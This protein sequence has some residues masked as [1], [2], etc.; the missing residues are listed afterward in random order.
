MEGIV[1]GTYRCHLRS[2][3]RDQ[4]RQSD[5]N[6]GGLGSPEIAADCADYADSVCVIRVFAAYDVTRASWASV[7]SPMMVRNRFT[8][9]ALTK[10]CGAPGFRYFNARSFSIVLS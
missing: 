5:Q 6:T 7:H 1:L 3:E 8:A 10:G 4:F 2:H 9:L